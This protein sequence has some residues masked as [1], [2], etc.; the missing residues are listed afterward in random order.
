MSEVDDDSVTLVGLR[1]RDDFEDKEPR[2]RDVELGKRLGYANPK[3]IRKVIKRLEE[4]GRLPGIS[5]RDA[6][7]RLKNAGNLPP[8]SVTEVWLDERSCLKVIAKSDTETADAILDE[9]IDVFMAYRRGKLLPRLL[10]DEPCAWDPMWTRETVSALCRVYNWPYYPGDSIPAP[11]ASVIAKIYRV[12]LEPENYE[13]MKAVN[14]EPR[15]GQNHHQWL[16]E[17]ARPRF[18]SELHMI[19]GFA[20]VACEYEEPSKAFWLM[21]E[22]HYL[23]HPMQLTFVGLGTRK[24]AA[25]KAGAA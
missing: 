1:L 10:A 13:A 25:L 18:R 23:S 17:Q 9:I 24:L 8:L 4:S 3:D 5:K 16:S 22:R 6:V 2:I 20:A 11:L 14:P 21:L 15:H 19:R 12:V 7:A